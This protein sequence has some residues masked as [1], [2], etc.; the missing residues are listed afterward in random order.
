MYGVGPAALLMANACKLAYTP[1]FVAVLWR[2]S[3]VD[4]LGGKFN[5]NS[6]HSRGIKSICHEKG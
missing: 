4:L 3:L 1:I 5:G 2:S 6:R